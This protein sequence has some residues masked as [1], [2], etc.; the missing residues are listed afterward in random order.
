MGKLAILIEKMQEALDEAT[1][2]ERDSA[3]TAADDVDYRELAMYQDV[4]SK[5]YVNGIL[6]LDDANLIYTSVGPGCSV[7]HWRKNSLATKI[8]ITML[9]GHLVSLNLLKTTHLDIYA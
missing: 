4:Q 2:A 5:S 6:A 3:E 8:A 9:I 1:Q 7:E